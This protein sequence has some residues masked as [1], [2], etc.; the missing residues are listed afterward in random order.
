MYPPEIIW[1]L[2]FGARH[3][4]EWGP[5]DPGRIEFPLYSVACRP[6]GLVAFSDNSSCA[7]SPF[8]LPSTFQDP[9]SLSA[10]LFFQ[11][12]S[13]TSSSSGKPP[14]VI[15]ARS[16]PFPLFLMG[17]LADT[18][19]YMLFFVV[20]FSHANTMG[21]VLYEWPPPHPPPPPNDSSLRC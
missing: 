21:N 9:L 1:A 16:L 10:C 15:E 3:R 6:D 20:W 12:H 17:A 11:R 7:S 8:Q 13:G 18:I 14:P 4:F 19:S 2:Y 5:L